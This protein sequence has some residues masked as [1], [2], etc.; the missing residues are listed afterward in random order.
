[1]LL[2]L[3]ASAT[4]FAPTVPPPRG[5]MLRASRDDAAPALPRRPSPSASA[6]DVVAAQ[7]NALK[8][9]DVMRCF[10]FASP[11]NKAATGPWRNF[12]AML[13]SNPDYSPMVQCSRWEFVGAIS[14]SDTTKVVRV[15]IFPAGGSSAPFAI[16]PSVSYNFALSKQP[17]S[18]D[19]VAGCWCTDS[20]VPATSGG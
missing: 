15:R 9:G 20:V 6:E 10:K 19:S 14:P 18:G 3:L 8:D 4:A 1:M 12:A 11:A 5:P 7:L 2:L 17:D 16:P 13:A